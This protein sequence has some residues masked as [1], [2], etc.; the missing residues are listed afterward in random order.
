[1]CADTGGWRFEGAFTRPF[2]SLHERITMADVASMWYGSEINQIG[3]LTIASFLQ[4][5]HTFT[6]YTYDTNVTVPK[7][8]IVIDANEVLNAS[9]IFGE[10]NIWQPFSDL[11]RYKLLMETDH[12][13]V[14]M[15]MVCLKDD[16]HFPTDYV[17]SLEN[18]V[19][20]GLRYNNAVLK[21]PRDSEPLQYM[22]ET[23][24]SGA[25]NE[26]LWFEPKGI[27]IN[28][29][30]V[31]LTDVVYQYDLSK[32]ALPKYAFYPVLTEESYK[33]LL[34]QHTSSI[35]KQSE[36]SHAVHMYGSLMDKKRLENVDKYSFVGV[37][38]Q[39]YNCR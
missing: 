12:I 10:N 23:T 35:L 8:T 22:Y 20:Y 17:F 32:Y 39:R 30:P 27:P 36:D 31:L 5:K 4:H 28:Y 13:W 33:F 25:H 6:L 9:H 1:M 29:G 24:L 18:T 19:E 7:G 11:F 15:D 3:R 38:Q 14:D 37:M 26:L 2:L 21:M 16:W 34:P